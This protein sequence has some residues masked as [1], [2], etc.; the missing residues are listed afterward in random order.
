MKIKEWFKK[1]KR[2]SEIKRDIRYF[3]ERLHLL[4]LNYTIYSIDIKK[5]M[6]MTMIREEERICSELKLLNSQLS[7]L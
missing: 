5:D 2:K 7:L 1:Q 3:K 6:F 4:H